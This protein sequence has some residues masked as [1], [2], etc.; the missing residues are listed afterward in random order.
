MLL[1]SSYKYWQYKNIIL[2]WL[3]GNGNPKGNYTLNIL[4]LYSVV[5]QCY[6]KQALIPLLLYVSCYRGL[7]ELVWPLSCSQR[8]SLRCLYLLFGQSCS[9]SCSSV[10]ACPP[11]LATSKEFLY[12]F[13]TWGFSPKVG[14]KRPPQVRQELGQTGT[15]HQLRQHTINLLRTKTPRWSKDGPA[16]LSFAR[17][18]LW[19]VCFWTSA[20]QTY[21]FQCW[22]IEASLL[23]IFNSCSLFCYRDNMCPLLH[24]WTDICPRLRELLAVTLW[25]LWRV[26]SSAD[27]C[28]LWDGRGCVPLWYW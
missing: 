1:I 12:H 19:P 2:A 27:H 3:Y 16:Y 23:N 7:K 20:I 26:H 10:S 25:Q 11:C 13:R 15:G 14:P 18:A 8:P 17:T 21:F 24:C 28:I 4:V 22:E 6:L 5:T 9:S